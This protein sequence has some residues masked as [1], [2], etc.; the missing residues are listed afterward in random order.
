MYYVLSARRSA[1]RVDARRMVSIRTHLNHAAE[2]VF[3]D[4]TKQ[5]S[6]D[7]RS[8]VDALLYGQPTARRITLQ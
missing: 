2:Q 6:L 8:Q 4:L 1:V 5:K 3:A 7:H